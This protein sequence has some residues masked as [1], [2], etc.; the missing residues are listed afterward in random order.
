MVMIGVVQT[1]RVKNQCGNKVK[2]ATS[3]SVHSK[4]K[5]MYLSCL[6]GLFIVEKNDI[7]F[8]S[9]CLLIPLEI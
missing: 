8:I 1:M 5:H 7:W 3:P 6:T 4:Q 9:V 2:A